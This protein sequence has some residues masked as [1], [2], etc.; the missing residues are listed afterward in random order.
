MLCHAHQPKQAQK[1]GNRLRDHG[2]QGNAVDPHS[3]L[4]HK[5]KIQHNVDHG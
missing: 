3:Q 1:G 4:R 5:Q 2:S